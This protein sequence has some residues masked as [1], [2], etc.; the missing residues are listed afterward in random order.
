MNSNASSADL[1]PSECDSTDDALAREL[2]FSENPAFVVREGDLSWMLQRA[3]DKR[4]K[5]M[6]RPEP[7][8]FEAAP[9]PGTRAKR[10]DFESVFKYQLAE[11]IDCEGFEAF[12]YRKTIYFSLFCSSEHFLEIKDWAKLHGL[13]YY[14][15]GEMKKLL[16]EGALRANTVRSWIWRGDRKNPFKFKTIKEH[17]P[18]TPAKAQPAQKQ[19]KSRLNQALLERDVLKGDLI[20]SRIDFLG[21]KVLPRP[22]VIKVEL[23]SATPESLAASL[24]LARQQKYEVALSHPETGEPLV[25]KDASG[26][27]LYVTRN[28]LLTTLD[29]AQAFQTDLVT[30]RNWRDRKGEQ[31]FEDYICGS[32]LANGQ[33]DAFKQKGQTWFSLLH[34]KNAFLPFHQW[35]LVYCITTLHHQN[36]LTAMVFKNQKGKSNVLEFVVQRFLSCPIDEYVLRKYTPGDVVKDGEYVNGTEVGTLAAWSLKLDMPILQL[37]SRCDGQHLNLEPRPPGKAQLKSLGAY[38]GQDEGLRF[39]LRRANSK[40]ALLCDKCKANLM[41]K[42]KPA[43]VSQGDEP[44][45]FRAAVNQKGHE[46]YFLKTPEGLKSL[47]EIS[48]EANKPYSTAVSY[49]NNR[50]KHTWESFAA[51][52]FSPPSAKGFNGPAR[53]LLQLEERALEQ[54]LLEEGEAWQ[55]E[56]LAHETLRGR[57]RVQSKTGFIKDT[58]GKWKTLSTFIQEHQPNLTQNALWRRIRLGLP[59]EMLKLSPDDLKNAIRRGTV[60]DALE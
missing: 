12:A 41:S 58:D 31:E 54:V 52:L 42:L 9:A 23:K 44:Y 27:K 20:Q 34:D 35:C 11:L 32:W 21:F 55:Y 25:L 53:T 13:K 43:Q 4:L 15:I 30:V 49:V 19:G 16:A 45:I 38:C 47:V 2:P 39:C 24:E 56:H 22:E 8:N 6:L 18:Q 33:I 10:D 60:G 48:R 57:I 36:R 37:I 40:V 51:S 46:S 1:D 50:L 29:L 26:S 5:V 3:K 17:S 28:R 59:L 14:R 7:E